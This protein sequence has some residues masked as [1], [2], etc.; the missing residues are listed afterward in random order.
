MHRR[1]H[2]Q[3]SELWIG[4]VNVVATDNDVLKTFVAPLIGDVASQFV[5][6]R[7]ASNMWL[8]GEDVMLAALFVGRR[9]RLECILDVD[10]MSG[11]GWSEAQNGSLGKNG[12]GGAKEKSESED[13]RCS[14][15]HFSA[16]SEIHRLS[17]L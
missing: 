17:D 12:E 4:T 1:N 7:G 11:V 14:P 5:V 9:D 13:A 8:G 16:F 6:A 15:W 10:L 2:F 3:R